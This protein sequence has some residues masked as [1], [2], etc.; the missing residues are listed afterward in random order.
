MVVVAEVV[1]W[2][3]DGGGDSPLSLLLLFLLFLSLFS[4]FCMIK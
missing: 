2:R 1:K 3:G 4:L